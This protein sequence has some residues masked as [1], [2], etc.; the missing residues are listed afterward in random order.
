MLPEQLCISQIPP[1]A[2]VGVRPSENIWVR[3]Y[4]FETRVQW[5]DTQGGSDRRCVVF[6]VLLF[7]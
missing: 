1:R 2:A 5:K 7:V 3:L 6:G 4:L